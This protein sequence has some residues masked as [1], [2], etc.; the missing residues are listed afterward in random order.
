MGAL[1]AG[2]R[3]SMLLLPDDELPFGGS[4]WENKISFSKMKKL[5]GYLHI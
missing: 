5:A 2:N 1:T 3:L 4:L